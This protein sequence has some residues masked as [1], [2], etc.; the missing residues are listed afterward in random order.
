MAGSN[1]TA[2]FKVKKPKQPGNQ[3]IPGL[4]PE[5]GGAV[6]GWATAA[7]GKQVNDFQVNF[8]PQK[9]PPQSTSP[10]PEAQE[11]SPDESSAV[12]GDARREQQHDL[13][14]DQIQQKMLSQEQNAAAEKEL[15]GQLIETSSAEYYSSQVDTTERTDPLLEDKQYIVTMIVNQFNELGQ[16]V[17]TTPDFYRVGNKLGQGAFGKVSIAQHKLTGHFVAVKSLPKRDLDKE[18]ECKR[19]VSQEMQILQHLTSHRNVVKLYDSFE[20]TSHLCFVMELCAG[21]DLLSYVRRRKK[22][23]EALAKYLFKQAAKSLAYCH[24]N[25][26][27]HRDIK[28]EN[29]LIDEEG[30]IKL[31]DFGVSRQLKE[32]E[33]LL[34]E[35]CGTPAYMAPE[36]H[37]AVGRIKGQPADVWSLGVCLYAMLVG[38]VPFRGKSIE[39]LQ[40]L[41]MKGEWEFPASADGLS[42][43]AKSLVQGM[44][45]KDPDSRMDIT[46]V[47]KHPW[48]RG[49]PKKLKIFSQTELKKIKVLSQPT[50]GGD[51]PQRL[52]TEVA[53]TVD[54]KH[55]SSGSPTKEPQEH[56]EDIHLIPQNSRN[57]ETKSVIL[58]PFNT[59]VS[60]KEFER[61]IQ[62]EPTSILKFNDK[63]REA[64]RQYEFNYN[65]EVDNGVMIS[66]SDENEV[67]NS[68]DA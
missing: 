10:M 31:C 48:L 22:L 54:D 5:T 15:K 55:L 17:V 41:I 49:C 44:L 30:S 64:N 68:L 2:P 38:M 47:V 25:L 23:D 56:L 37:R 58:A 7:G 12:E 1:S 21:G 61:D 26:V 24:K 60:N 14:D 40:Q 57:I 19:R 20:T 50:N 9:Q 34:S 18:V 27:L 33:E 16:P 42:K 52:L 65:E 62:V 53:L 51:E 32:P 8:H 29:L 63:A 11:E 3:A 45:T 39:E 4:S 28:L 67:K 59:T 43:H 35:Q 6:R 36:V 46:Q 13:L 66:Q